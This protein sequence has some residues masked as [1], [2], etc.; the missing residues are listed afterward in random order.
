MA[1]RVGTFRFYTALLF[2]VSLLFFVVVFLRSVFLIS[3]KR[4]VRWKGIAISLK[5]RAQ[6]Q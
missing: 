3:I 4:S 2:P 5:D 1:F 6:E